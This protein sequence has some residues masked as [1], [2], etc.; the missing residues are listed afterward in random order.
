MSV[1]FHLAKHLDIH[2]A[3]TNVSLGALAARKVQAVSLTGSFADE[4]LVFK[5]LAAFAWDS[6]TSG[7]GPLLVGL[8]HSGYTNTTIEECLEAANLQGSGL[9]ATEQAERLVSPMATLDPS[10]PAAFVEES[11]KWPIDDNTGIDHW[12]YN[13]SGTA[14]TSGSSLICALTLFGRWL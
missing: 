4:F 14:L 5:T 13:M 7:Q 11:R 1:V 10:N 9:I 6:P 8:C 2:R 3:T 12:A